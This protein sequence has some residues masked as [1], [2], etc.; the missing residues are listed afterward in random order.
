M[1]EAA[2]EG[3]RPYEPP[4][5]RKVRVVPEE[6][7]AAGCKTTG[8]RRAPAGRAKRSSIAPGEA[9]G[10]GGAAIQEISFR[11]FVGERRLLE[12]RAPLDGALELTARAI[13]PA[14]TAT[15]TARQGTLGR[16]RANSHSPRSSGPS[17]G[18]PKP[19]ACT[20]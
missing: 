1:A 17:T 4:L 18:S 10:M 13:S 9:E 2:K 19:A 15:S 6:L 5:I 16:R 3:R 11:Q 7:A 8:L 14:G 12:R 20:F